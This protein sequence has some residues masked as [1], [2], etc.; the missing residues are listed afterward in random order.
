[1]R[2]GHACGAVRPS[3]GAAGRKGAGARLSTPVAPVR[4]TRITLCAWRSTSCWY[5]WMCEMGW[6]SR[7]GCKLS[8]AGATCTCTAEAQGAGGRSTF[9]PTIRGKQLFHI[10]GVLLLKPASQPT[11]TFTRRGANR[12]RGCGGY[13]RRN[14]EER[15]GWSLLCLSG[16]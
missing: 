8:C 5:G 16:V 9:Q 14:G 12:L 10:K 7:R 4:V 13:A 1:M 15:T 6:C 11:Y 2:D 3:Q